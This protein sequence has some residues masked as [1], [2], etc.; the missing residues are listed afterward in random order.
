M[1]VQWLADRLREKGCRV[2]TLS[3]YIREKR[4]PDAITF[5]GKE[6]IALEVETEK[7]W[8]PSHA[9]TE[10]RLCRLNSLAHF[11]DKTRVVFPSAKDSIDETGPAFLARVL[12]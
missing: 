9:S 4:V 3:E 8:K 6:L 7:R 1:V 5:D 2:F 11:F 12:S 10:E